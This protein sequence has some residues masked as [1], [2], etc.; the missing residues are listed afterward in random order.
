MDKV[1]KSWQSA[2]IC[3]HIQG[4]YIPELLTSVLWHGEPNGV[5]SGGRGG[6]GLVVLFQ[7]ISCRTTGMCVNTRTPA[8]WKRTRNDSKTKPVFT[9]YYTI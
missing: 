4:D 3:F 5:G 9:E 7:G 6:R 8:G 1:P 2:P